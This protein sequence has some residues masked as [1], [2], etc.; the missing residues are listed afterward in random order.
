ML[1]LILSM[2]GSAFAPSIAAATGI[3]ALASPLLMGAVGSGV[4]TL[5]ETGD[6][7][8]ALGAGI[9]SYAGGAAMGA[10]MGPAAGAVAP[11]QVAAAGVPAGMAGPATSAQM[12]NFPKTGGFMNPV[13]TGANFMKSPTGIGMT[14]GSAIGTELAPSSTDK[15][16]PVGTAPTLVTAPIQPEITPPPDTYRPGYDPEWDYGFSRYARGGM[17]SKYARPNIPGVGK[18]RLSDGGITTLAPIPTEARRSE[19][20]DNE[21]ELIAGAVAAIKG[22]AEKPELALG[23]FLAKYGENALR[24]LVDQVQSGALGNTV[25]RSEGKMEGPGDGMSD[26][27][28]AKVDGGQDVLLSDG[29]FVV[30]ADVVS[31]LGNGSTDAG[32]RALHRMMDRVRSDR[33]GTKEQPEAVSEDEMLPA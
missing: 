14:V 10:L 24:D 30:P 8:K 2:L 21:K 4:G 20:D 25:A 5:A 6:I 31:G 12:A 33:T 26:K 9:G 11:G 22:Q 28:P 7:K 16:K 23:R 3:S 17:L 15:K 1:P 32:V 18:V 19:S 27:I 29:E 13:Q